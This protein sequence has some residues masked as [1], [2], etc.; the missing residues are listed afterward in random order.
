MACVLD[1]SSGEL[2]IGS[3]MTKL[4]IVYHNDIAVYFHRLSK[5]YAL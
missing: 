4:H 5:H 3:Q 1:F 2:E